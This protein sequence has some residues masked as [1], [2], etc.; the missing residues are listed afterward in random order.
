MTR[1]FF[2]FHSYLATQTTN[3]AQIFTGFVFYAYVELTPSETTGLWHLPIVSTAFNIISWRYYSDIVQGYLLCNC[4]VVGPWEHFIL[5]SCFLM[6]S[7]HPISFKQPC[8]H[9]ADVQRSLHRTQCPQVLSW[10]SFWG[11]HHPTSVCDCLQPGPDGSL[12]GGWPRGDW[13]RERVDWDSAGGVLTLVGDLDG[14]SSRH[15][16]YKFEA[17]KEFLFL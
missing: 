16:R 7:N 10:E 3:Q 1:L 4:E 5:H 14:G 12:L 11:A 6:K 8:L 13:W 2:F 9:L 15:V 17:L